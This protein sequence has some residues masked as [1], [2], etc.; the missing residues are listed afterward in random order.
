V[1]DGG[2]LG[3]CKEGKEEGGEETE[4]SKGRKNSEGRE[5]ELDDCEGGGVG[6]G[7]QGNGVAKGVMRG[8]EGG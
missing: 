3:G 5:E 4:P 8:D 2:R 6:A 1:G 7:R